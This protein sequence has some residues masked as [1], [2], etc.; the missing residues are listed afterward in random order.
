MF[1]ALLRLILIFAT[2]PIQAQDDDALGYHFDAVGKVVVTDMQK[3]VQNWSP[4]NILTFQGVD[5][6][7]IKGK[8]ISISPGCPGCE[9]KQDPNGELY[10]EG[11][12][13][14]GPLK[15]YERDEDTHTLQ[16]YTVG[17]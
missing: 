16:S 1:Y 2:H 13:A 8:L 10:I 12:M 6:R 11:P 4:A 3:F 9:L 15:L 14:R 7:L 5:F 17:G